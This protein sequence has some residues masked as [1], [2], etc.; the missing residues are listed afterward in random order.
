MEIK[1]LIVKEYLESL[2][3]KNELNRIF[4]LL[5]EV[6]NFQ[7]L[8]KPTEY[9]GIQEYGKDIVAVGIDEDGVKK[10]FYFELKGGADRNITEEN[11]YGKDGIQD[12]LTQSSYNKFVSAYPRFDHLPLKIVIVHNGI[13]KGTVQSTLESFFKKLSEHIP[14]TTFERWDISKLVLLF[15]EYLFS[16]YLLVDPDSRKLFNRVLINLDSYEGIVPDF[17][18]LVTTILNKP[19]SKPNLKSLSR[20][21]KL[22]FESINLLA[23]II[24]TEAQEYNNLEIAKRYLTQLVLL[25]WHWILVNKLETNKNV[26][27][28]FNKLF[29]F[30][31]R[32]LDEYFKRVLPI[33]LLKDGIFSEEAGRYEQ[34]GYTMRTFEVLS[35]WLCFLKMADHFEINHSEVKTLLINIINNN[36]VSSRPLLD[37]HSIPIID[38]LLFFINRNDF[39]SA[40]SYMNNVLTNLQWGKDNYDRL[41][42]TNNSIENVIKFIV[43]GKKPF[44]YSDSTSPLIA[45]LL[46]FTAILNL[47]SAYYILRDF[48]LKHKIDL[49][50]FVPHHGL[51]STSRHLIEDKEQDL[52]EQLFYKSFNDGYQSELRLTLTKIEEGIWD[53][54]LDF[55]NFKQK[56]LARKQEFEYVYRTD[57]SGFSFLRD[58]AHLFYKT[59]YFPDKWRTLFV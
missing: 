24:Y 47:E 56:I 31:F 11:F 53:S 1:N 33:S 2:T 8:S 40:Q 25:F 6:R 46:E 12:S 16:P 4:P 43:T 22:V 51:N 7:I 29:G 59:P 50:L 45:A 39:V 57:K 42:D 41:P 36:S 55:E 58:I 38:V 30:Y 34:V 13:I 10:R 44:Y 18:E 20:Q 52:E 27:P 5:L 37:I 14:N 19:Q 26:L 17:I 21:W 48:V 15:S 9:I 3:E 35:Y 54:Q 32:V 49:G 28:Y 23:F